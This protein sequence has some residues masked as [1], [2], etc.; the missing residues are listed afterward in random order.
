MGGEPMYKN[1]LAE[2]KR[3]DVSRQSL[4]KHIGISVVNLCNKLNLKN[5][6]KVSELLKILDFFEDKGI[7]LTADYILGIE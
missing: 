1:L 6:L 4:A 2:M 3:H 5:E 7:K